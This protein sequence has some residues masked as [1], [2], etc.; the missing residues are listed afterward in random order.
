[1]GRVLF[2]RSEKCVVVG[3]L[4]LLIAFGG[5]LW[6]IDSQKERNIINSGELAS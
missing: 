4:K 5:K 3:S 2:L 6:E 1:M